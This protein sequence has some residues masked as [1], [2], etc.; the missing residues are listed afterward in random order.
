MKPLLNW[1]KS[2]FNKPEV[3]LQYRRFGIFKE[4][5]SFE[6]YLLHN[7]M[8]QR[9]FKAGEV[10]FEEGYPMEV[11]YFIEKGEISLNDVP[12]TIGRNQVLGLWDLFS[13]GKRNS[14][15]KAVTDVSAFAIA[16]SE[17]L[18]LLDAKPRMGIRILKAICAELATDAIKLRAASK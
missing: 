15:A 9:S 18:E 4:L 13:G 14:T 5:H 12:H 11:I 17:F 1:F 6:L 3:Y 16:E 7:N 10:L 2:L 8:H